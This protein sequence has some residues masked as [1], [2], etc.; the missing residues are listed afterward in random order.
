MN[1]S[2]LRRL[3]VPEHCLKT[4]LGAVQV[5]AKDRGLRGR[6]L[7]DR[8][9]DVLTA[10]EGFTDDADLGEFAQ[11]V[12]EDR[13]YARPEPI[14]YRTWGSEIDEGAPPNAAVLF[15]AD[16]ARGGADA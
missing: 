13:S 12:I 14:T 4:A 16:G 2:Q 3:G 1:N 11:D 5:L 15:A 7:K 6:A 9:K 8:L 10:P